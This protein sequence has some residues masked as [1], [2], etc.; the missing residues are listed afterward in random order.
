MAVFGVQSDQILALLF[1]AV[2]DG[3]GA[4]PHRRVDG[5]RAGEDRC[6]PATTKTDPTH[7]PLPGAGRW[8]AGPGAR[9][10]EAGH[11]VAP[12]VRCR[13][14]AA[15]GS[16]RRRRAAPPGRRRRRWG[17][18]GAGTL[19]GLAGCQH[20]LV[21]GRA[22]LGL[23]AQRRVQL[24]PGRAVVVRDDRARRAPSGV[25]G[26]QPVRRP[27]P[28][29]GVH[30]RPEAAT[31]GGPGVEGRAVPVQPESAH[32]GQRGAVPDEVLHP[33]PG[34]DTRPNPIGSF[35]VMFGVLLKPRGGGGPK[36]R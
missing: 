25:E 7:P 21:E 30:L 32:G 27:P 19:A 11:T 8:R 36:P 2:P 4:S 24:R 23:G 34:S 10:G 35:D 12:P 33:G 14:T 9:G 15:P 16:R 17:G 6:T 26:E 29:Q 18:G 31:A 13:P 28:V 22:G 5:V 3:R 1:D 20:R